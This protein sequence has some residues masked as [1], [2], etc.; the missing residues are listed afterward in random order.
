[1]KPVEDKLTLE[2]LRANGPAFS[3]NGPV[4]KQSHRTTTDSR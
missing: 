3:P 2:E 4:R 1:M